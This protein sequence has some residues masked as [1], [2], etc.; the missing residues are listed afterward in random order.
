MLCRLIRVA[1]AA[2]LAGGCAPRHDAAP[3]R[4]ADVSL[5]AEIQIIEAQVPVRTTLERL[6]R[7]HHL[8]ND[9]VNAAVQATRGVF[10]PRELRANQPYKLVTS[11]DGLLREFEVQLDADRFLRIV[12][13]DRAQPAAL[14]AQVLAYDKQ[15][16]VVSVEGRID[17]DHP[18]L[19]AAMDETG[20]NVQLALGLADIFAGQID[21]EHDLQPDD[22]FRLLFEKSTRDGQFAGYGAI[23]AATFE[24]GGRPHQA[25]RWT[26]PQSGKAGYYDRDGRSLKRFFLASPLKFVV[27]PRVTS[28]FST[29]RLHPIYRE[30]RAHLGVDYGAPIGAPVVAVANGVVVSAGYSGGGGNMI[31]LRH[32]SGYETYYLHLSSFGKG[33]R[34]G[35]RVEQG[36]VIG[37]VGMTGAATGP[38]LDYRLRR[39]GAFVNPLLERRRL[40]PGDPIPAVQLADF[41]TMRDRLTT[42]L[43]ATALADAA[44]KPDAVKAA[45]PR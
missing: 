42:Q 43:S 33:I 23:L 30:Y 26:N 21:F 39:N 40:P 20:E 13:R 35:A 31:R 6:L 14:D 3:A 37:R 32:A 2:A 38:H 34:A 7:E 18:S 29:H 22:R 4:H 1:A 27:S 9:L 28:G 15:T 41:R 5:A 16:A 12:N 10:N 17:S 8:P 11:L 19:I 25:Y 44:S 24:S 45:A 36:Q